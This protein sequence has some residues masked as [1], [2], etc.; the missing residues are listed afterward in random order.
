MDIEPMTFNEIR[1]IV[2]LEPIIESEKAFAQLYSE[3]EK[4]NDDGNGK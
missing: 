2:G 1:K 4:E 3:K